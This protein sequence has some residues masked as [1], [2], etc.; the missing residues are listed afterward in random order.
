VEV[1]TLV[2]EP[3]RAEVESVAEE[4]ALGA[5][6]VEGAPVSEPTEARDEGIVAVVPVQTAQGSMVPVV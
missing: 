6:G 5:P 1:E 2:L 3:P 4:T